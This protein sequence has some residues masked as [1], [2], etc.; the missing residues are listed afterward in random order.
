MGGIIGIAV[1][2]FG[3]IWT[4][5]AGK[6]FAPMALFGIIFVVI[7][8]ANTV[9]NFKNATGEN[10][11]SEYDIVDDTE[12]PDPLNARFG[13]KSQNAVEVNFTDVNKAHYC[14]YCGACVSEGYKFCSNCGR[15]LP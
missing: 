2:I 10:R 8:I 5:L 15:Q 9:Y 11:Y 6:M 3:L 13:K 14:P 12:E 4:F 7:G 1:V